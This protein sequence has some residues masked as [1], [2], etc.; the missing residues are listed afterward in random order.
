MKNQVNIQLPASHCY[1]NAGEIGCSI[2]GIF[3]S[4]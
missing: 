1:C 4:A 2:S 3:R